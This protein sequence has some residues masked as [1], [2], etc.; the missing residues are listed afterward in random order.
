M[1]LRGSPHSMQIAHP[2]ERECFRYKPLH[3][4]KNREHFPLRDNEAGKL[5]AS[6]FSR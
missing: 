6:Q 2:Q 3:F 5:M 4:W 1:L